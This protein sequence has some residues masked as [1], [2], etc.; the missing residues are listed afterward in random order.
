MEIKKLFYKYTTLERRIL[1]LFCQVGSDGIIKIKDKYPYFKD[2]NKLF[3][4]T[5]GCIERIYNPT[6]IIE[7]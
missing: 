5:T 2:G 7:E 6:K 1:N 4:L 3:T